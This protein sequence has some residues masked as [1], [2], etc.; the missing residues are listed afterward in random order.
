MYVRKACTFQASHVVRY[1]LETKLDWKVTILGLG[2]V[3]LS[4]SVYVLQRLLHIYYAD[5]ISPLLDLVS[6]V[7]KGY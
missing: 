1:L 3:V 6:R 4:Y 5:I 7:Y 2:K